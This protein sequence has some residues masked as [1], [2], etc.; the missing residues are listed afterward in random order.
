M[1]LV[2]IIVQVPF[3]SWLTLKTASSSS[4]QKFLKVSSLN[5]LDVIVELQFIVF[6]QLNIKTS[7]TYV[8]C[9]RE[10][11]AKSFQNVIICHLLLSFENIQ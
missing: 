7:Y 8:I 5:I 11:K 3:K 6:M 1:I 10:N 2:N 4:F 9:T